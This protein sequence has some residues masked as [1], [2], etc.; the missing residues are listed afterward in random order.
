MGPA[1]T[2]AAVFWAGPGGCAE[3]LSGV[4]PF[5]LTSQRPGHN[6]YGSLS[7]WAARAVAFERTRRIPVGGCICILPPAT[8]AA[9]A[10]YNMRWRSWVTLCESIR[11]GYGGDNDGGRS[12]GCAHACPAWPLRRPRMRQAPAVWVT[13]AQFTERCTKRREPSPLII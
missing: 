6:P 5:S 2:S 1:E 7:L 11:Y 9:Q 3:A 8:R 4:W 10:L 13:L 12:D